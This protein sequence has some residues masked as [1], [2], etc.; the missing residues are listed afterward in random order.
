MGDAAEH[1]PT[2]GALDS[3]GL[4]ALAPALALGR[5]AIGAGLM[6]APGRTLEALGFEESSYPTVV[7]ARL[8]GGRDLVLGALMGLALGDPER[9]RR[10]TLAC[11]AADA[12]DAAIF[13]AAIAEGDDSARAAGLR[14]LAAAVP[15]ALAGLWVARRLR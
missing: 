2:R 9:L 11:A 5:I 4:R 10:A 8:A 15:A 6:L 3:P 14:G 7:V 12:G 13:A 1:P